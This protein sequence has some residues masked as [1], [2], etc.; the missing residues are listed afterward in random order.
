MGSLDATCAESVT[1][2]VGTWSIRTVGV[3]VPETLE[4][5]VVDVRRCLML[6]FVRESV[7]NGFM[8]NTIGTMSMSNHN[9]VHKFG[10]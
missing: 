5:P 2:I 10:D 8:L 3:C 7:W 1:P 4:E 6:G 9:L